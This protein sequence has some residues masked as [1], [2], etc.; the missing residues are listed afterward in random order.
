MY[1]YENYKTFLTSNTY[2][3][4]ITTTYIIKFRRY[5]E[6]LLC[7]E[8]WNLNLYDMFIELFLF[9]NIVTMISADKI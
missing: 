4:S 5:I 3:Y 2:Y 7:S 9:L 6:G 1:K 8:D